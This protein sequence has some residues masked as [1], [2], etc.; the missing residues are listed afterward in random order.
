[1][2]RLTNKLLNDETGSVLPLIAVVIIIFILVGA[3]QIGNIFVYRDRAVVRD[4]IDSACTSAL[5]SGTVL[6]THSTNYTEQHIVIWSTPTE[7]SPSVLIADYWIPLESNTKYN[8]HLDQGNAEAAAKSNFQKIIA[9]NNI[10]A[11]LISWNFSVVYDNDRYINV[12]QSRFNTSLAGSWWAYPSNNGNISVQ[13]PRWVKVTITASVS[14]PVLLGGTFGK[15]TQNFTW[16]SQA[17]KELSPDR[18]F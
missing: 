17:I 4:A 5:V 2:K 11:S 3:Y 7:F 12:S 18:I 14:V 9:G 16:K 8:L 6:E 13:A 10:K 1:M 15:P